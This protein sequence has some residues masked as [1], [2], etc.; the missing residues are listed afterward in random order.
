MSDCFALAW[1][2]VRIVS[3]RKLEPIVNSIQQHLSQIKIFTVLLQAKTLFR[4]KKKPDIL[5][6]I[7]CQSNR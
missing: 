6:L 1:H 5:Q 3:T 7:V 2:Y 4:L